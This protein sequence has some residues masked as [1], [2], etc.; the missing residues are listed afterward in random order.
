M[1]APRLPRLL[2]HAAGLT[3]ARSV[4]DLTARLY[5]GVNEI[6]GTTMVGFD[7]LDPRTRRPQFTSGSGVSDFFL[8]RYDDVARDR[9]PVLA[10]AM[11]EGHIAYNLAM[12]SESE[13]R[14]QR[15]YRDAF[16]LHRMVAVAYAPVVVDGRI[17]ATLNL[18]R[19][20][21]ARFSEDELESA[22]ALAALVGSVLTA[23]R[24]E[25]D[26][27]DQ[28]A[29]YRDAIDLVDDAVVITDLTRA[30]R[31]T[32]RAAE[33][34]L[35]AQRPGARSLDDVLS[36]SATDGPL[37]RGGDTLVVRSVTVND[38]RAVVAFLGPDTSGE[39]L[40]EWLCSSLSPREF[41]VVSLVVRGLRDHDVARE[42][43]LSVHTVKGHLR[44]AYLKTGARSRTELT[45]MALGSADARDTT[46]LERGGHAKGSNGAR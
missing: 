36:S 18:G 42:L 21:G 25:Q 26:L 39:R 7:I 23:H 15:V 22:A 40:P 33:R 11:L 38:G 24:R 13:W 16:A 14:S 3:Q 10:H 31:F 45:S 12:M 29:L 32:N 20:E 5:A 4:D 8:A 19:G 30:T 28:V 9:D 1:L 6:I 37:P 44:E 27:T 35:A 17:T 34:T 46:P 43:N 41:D 2:S